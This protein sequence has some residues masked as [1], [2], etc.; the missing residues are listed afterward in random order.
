M[1]ASTNGE[2]SGADAVP[3]FSDSALANLTSRIQQGFQKD[4]KPETKPKPGKKEKNN[5]DQKPKKDQANGPQ[6]QLKPDNTTNKGQKRDRKG[7]PVVEQKQASG[8]QEKKGKNVKDD[9]T[10]RQEILAF[11]GTED[12]YNLLAGVDSDSEYGNSGN[13]SEGAEEEALRN[14]MARMMKG[15]NPNFVMPELPKK[16]AKPAK[17]KMKK[18]E[19][20]KPQPQKQEKTSSPTEEE[21][22]KPAQQKQKEVKEKKEQKEKQQKEKQQKEKEQ[23]EKK[24]KEAQKP[25]K[26]EEKKENA[27]KTEKAAAPKKEQALKAKNSRFMIEPRPDWHATEL[28]SIAPATHARVA[29]RHVIDQVHEYANSLL[30]AEN[31]EYSATQDSSTHKFYSTIV[32]TGTLSDKTSALTLA[33]Q[34]SP[35]HNTK[36]LDS[37]VGLA[38][39]RSRAQAVEV[40]RSLKDLFA[41]G[42]VLPS[43]RRLRAFHQQPALVSA[44]ADKR[45][46]S[47]RDPL[48]GDITKAH[49]VYWAY[50][51]YL[52]EQ[53]FEILK[54]L[55][56]WC[57]DEIE[58]SRSRAVSYVFELLKEKPEQETNLLRLLVNKLGDPNKKIASRASY[59]LL[60]LEQAHP[61]MKLTVINA[62]EADIL[63]RPNQ[64]QHAKY[65][66]VITLNQT[67]LSR[68][69]EKVAAKLLDIYFGMFVSLLKP[70]KQQQQKWRKDKKKSKAQ[71]QK[72]AQKEAEKGQA[73]EAELREK[74]VAGVLTGVNRAYPFMSENTER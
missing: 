35:L 42:D 22:A 2:A 3:N 5:K 29:A 28:P 64:S 74:L 32:T 20:E 60:Q 8:K 57:N 30:E 39:K 45:Y 69:D 44:F 41:Q 49:L 37:L 63:F 40:L 25:Q 6:Q 52:K 71:N 18:A 70:A 13:N 38:K 17:E 46:W 54:I 9:E 19:A 43:S 62:I 67:I 23:K 58:F 66:A 61:L 24:E 53:Y 33:I 14:E 51:D 72:E 65:Y 48:P 59:L 1:S 68:A 27:N 12:D 50:E 11:G 55:E 26:K 34:E 15:F 4:S 47:D 10:L 36:S 7:E 56:V 31:K 73:Q 21:A 16:E